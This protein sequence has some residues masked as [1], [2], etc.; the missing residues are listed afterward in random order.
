V[1]F[2]FALSSLRRSSEELSVIW[3]TLPLSISV[4]ATEVVCPEGG[5]TRGLDGPEFSELR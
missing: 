4:I 2:S 1:D 5:T 3:R